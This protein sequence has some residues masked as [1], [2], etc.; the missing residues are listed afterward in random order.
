MN[1][2]HV[3]LGRFSSPEWFASQSIG[4]FQRIQSILAQG[5]QTVM[6][7]SNRENT[8]ICACTFWYPRLSKNFEYVC[9]LKIFFLFNCSDLKE[10]NSKPQT[11]K[12]AIS[13]NKSCPLTVGK[14]RIYC[15]KFVFRKVFFK[16]HANASQYFIVTFL[17]ELLF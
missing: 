15:T 3:S 2:I 9:I 7:K 12:K 10:A 16:E 4:C 1:L 11:Y 6:M 8:F 5:K 13:L 14:L 17:R